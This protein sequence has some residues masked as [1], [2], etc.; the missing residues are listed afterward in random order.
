M[1]N[2][3]T[4]QQ[5][6]RPPTFST[7]HF[8]MALVIFCLVMIGPRIAILT[9]YV[10]GNP[11]A[12][13]PVTDGAVY[14]DW[15]GRIATGAPSD[16]VPFVSAPL[17]PYVVGLIR[18]FGGGL[19]TLYVVQ[20]VLDILTALGLAWVA[21]RR[22]TPG[23]AL[24]AL[25][26]WFLLDEPAFYL[27][28]VLNSTLQAFLIVLFWLVLVFWQERPSWARS[29]AVGGLLGLNCLANPPMML[30]VG[31][32]PIWMVLWVKQRFGAPQGDRRHA[33]KAT[34]ATP[35]RSMLRAALMAAAAVGLCV[36]TISPATIHNLRACDEFIPITA[37]PGITLRQ[38]NGPGAV[39]TYVPIPGIS[40]GRDRLFEDAAK[41]YQQSTG[42]PA[43]WRE[44]DRFFRDQALD[45]W[46]ADWSRAA[47]LFLRRLWWFLSGRYYCDVHQPS[48]ERDTG[49]ARFLW[50]APVPTAWLIGPGIVG[51][52]ALCRRPMRSAPEWMLF[53]VPLLV[54]VVFQYSPRYRFPA[55]P[56]L[57][58]TAAYAFRQLW[59]R[60]SR[61]R[62]APVTAAATIA[63]IAAGPL[64]RATG[65]ED[66]AGLAYNNHYNL[67]VAQARLGRND[68]AIRQLETALSL[69]R[70]SPEAHNDL[71]VLLS[72][73]G[74][75]QKAVDHYQ[76]ALKLRPGWAQVE[77][78]LGLAHAALRQF[79]AALEHLRRATKARP[80]ASDLAFHL[81]NVLADAGKNAEA[82]DE[83]RRLLK[84]RPDDPD[85]LD[86]LG[87]VRLRA[88]AIDEAVVAWRRV[89]DVAPDRAGTR[90][91]LAA[92]L[93]Q[94][95]QYGQAVA[96]LREGLRRQPQQAEMANNL[97][98]LLATCPQ[99]DL[100][101]GTEA[102]ALAEAIC[103][104]A[105]ATPPSFLDSLA[106]A[107]AETGR[108]DLAV[109]T[110]EKALAIL[111]QGG[112]T[113]QAQRL[114]SRLELYRTGK[115]YR[116]KR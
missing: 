97:A 66:P 115:P 5:S 39:G 77:G 76:Q 1:P 79:D 101:Q 95:R 3:D 73:R 37:C 63:G 54:V 6:L 40:G 106:A 24:L 27:T 26:A 86:H 100:R 15:A 56:I 17:Y 110:A 35:D 116:E 23:L 11:F 84:L 41:V 51:L 85:A 21:R 10:R 82:A 45:Y 22:S 88:G 90:N 28:R 61:W 89:L 38:G 64:N 59:D 75:W 87:V 4:T 43:R 18:W 25:L 96:V 112:Q 9:E 105:D 69:N 71:A 114:A 80:D 36:A 46:R 78:N 94:Q 103:R 113:D 20:L 102:V 62:W 99:D 53:A 83:Y 93:A 32:V 7:Q 58:V 109:T 8:R 55:V 29:L 19:T 67:A 33:A 34:H 111:R 108:F 13:A 47:G 14:W 92:A 30:L 70:G 98:W 50:L 68:E 57:V 91:N 60:P 42:H 48:W 31:L 49:L 81:G 44:V 52:I 65:F 16:Q 104:R 107:Y 2:R 72:R 74:D 12:K